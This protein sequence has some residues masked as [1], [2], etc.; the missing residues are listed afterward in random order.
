MLL[1]FGVENYRSI[2]ERQEL[3][4]VA[5]SLDDVSTGL[6]STPALPNARLV[7]AVIIYGA[8]AAGKSNIVS[9]FDWMRNAVLYSHSR[10]E[11]G[12]PVKISPFL[13]DE[14]W[15]ARPTTFDVDFILENVRYQ[16]GFE[17]SK[18]AYISEWLFAYPNDRR[19]M[20]FD[21]KGSE[22]SFGRSLKGQNKIIAELARPNS[23]YLSVA[24]QNS[25]VQLSRISGFI[26]TIQI[27]NNVGTHYGSPEID[28]IDARVVSFL[29]AIGTGIVSYREIEEKEKFLPDEVERTK[30][31]LKNMLNEKPDI[32]LEQQL[33]KLEK[34]DYKIQLAHQGPKEKVVYLDFKAE[35]DG[36]KR[37]YL[38]LSYAFRAL[39]KGT[40]FISDELDA[41][42]HT[43]ACEALVS[44]FTAPETNPLG[45]Q[46]IATTHDTNLL[47]SKMLRRDQVWFAEKTNEGATHLYPLTDIR[48]RKGDNLEKAY[49]QGRYGA[50]GVSG[51]VKDILSAL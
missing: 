30:S 25:H 24:T 26:E 27:E 16:Y 51:S 14:G 46:L 1:R 15:A 31:A 20:L 39:D 5:S 49:L 3:S 22:F 48:T 45:A 34:I 42:L 41:S 29:G 23:L 44:L 28:D 6:I 33:K 19:Q 50:V 11:P 21:R 13:L 2:K 8:N 32:R 12:G 10:G 4:L 18:E 38:L 43:Q 17:A 36:T 7:P 40:I 47:Q 35:S 9:A 37:L